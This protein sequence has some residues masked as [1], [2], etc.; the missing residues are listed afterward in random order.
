M[1]LIEL[2]GNERNGISKLY[3]SILSTKSNLPLCLSV[4]EIQISSI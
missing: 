1:S 2:Q 4:T 3:P